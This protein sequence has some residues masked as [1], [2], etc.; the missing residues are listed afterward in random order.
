MRYA[1]LRGSGGLSLNVERANARYLIAG[2]LASDLYLWVT[3]GVLR[4]WKVR[5]QGT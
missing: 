4:W 3:V 5:Q 1:G 2:D